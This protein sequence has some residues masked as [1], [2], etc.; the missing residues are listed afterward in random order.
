VITL[1]AFA[2]TKVSVGGKA[3]EVLGLTLDYHVTLVSI[4][5]QRT[6]AKSGQHV[7]AE[8]VSCCS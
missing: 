2:L 3:M 6:D 4:R 8:Q 1:I 7:M 5:N